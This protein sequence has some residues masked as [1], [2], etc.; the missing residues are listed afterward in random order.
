MKDKSELVKSKWVEIAKLYNYIF[1]RIENRLIN[2]NVFEWNKLECDN[3]WLPFPFSC[4][5]QSLTFRETWNKVLTAQSCHKI[6]KEHEDGGL[7]TWE[8]INTHVDQIIVLLMRN[9]FMKKIEKMEL[10]IQDELRY[11]DYFRSF[12]R[13][14]LSWESQ[15]TPVNLNNSTLFNKYI[16]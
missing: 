16:A 2:E 15:K 13:I 10:L 14:T 9:I 8:R 12:K 11:V 7:K 6:L 4:T 1:L 3:Y 5:W